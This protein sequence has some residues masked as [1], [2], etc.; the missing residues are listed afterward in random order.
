MTLDRRKLR[1]IIG[2]EVD[3]PEAFEEDC[4]RCG[5]SESCCVCRE[6]L[7]N[8]PGATKWELEDEENEQT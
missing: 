3:P 7:A 6:E 4:L 8:A 2:D 5:E 1:K